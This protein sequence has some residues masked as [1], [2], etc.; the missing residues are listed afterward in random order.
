MNSGYWSGPIKFFRIL[1]IIGYMN[2]VWENNVLIFNTP[3]YIFLIILMLKNLILCGFWVDSNINKYT[4]S[5]TQRGSSVTIK[6]VENPTKTI[7]LTHKEISK[8]CSSKSTFSLQTLRY[9]QI[10]ISCI[11]SPI[12][13]NN[14]AVR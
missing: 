10:Y 7:R 5:W 1:T 3:L 14:Y 2:T 12:Y 4:D 6:L 11:F 8:I 9:I 13:A